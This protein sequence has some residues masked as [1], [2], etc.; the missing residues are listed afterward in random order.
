MYFKLQ[1]LDEYHYSFTG[2][3]GGTIRDLTKSFPRW[4]SRDGVMDDNIR[5][6]GPFDRRVA[7]PVRSVL[8][9]S[10]DSIERKFGAFGRELDSGYEPTAFYLE[11]RCRNHFGRSMAESYL[12]G[13]ITLSPMLD[14]DLHRIKPS[15]SGCSEQDVLMTVIFDRYEPGL[16]DFEFE[17]GGRSPHPPGSSRTI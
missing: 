14:S 4:D 15:S 17:G 3:G 9:R 13:P 12:S 16:L 11:T 5:K 7:D 10:F 1:S 6:A 2:N 8:E